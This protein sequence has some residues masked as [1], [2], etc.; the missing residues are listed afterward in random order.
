MTRLLPLLM[1]ALA[2]CTPTPGTGNPPQP[3][4]ADATTGA[5][6]AAD[7]LDAWH[8]HLAEATGAD[9]ARIA[10]LFANP[11]Q[12]LQLDF[13]QGRISVSG[14][15][16]R[17]GGGYR[18]EGG[19]LHVEQ[20][21]QTQ[22]ACPQPLMEQDAAIARL[23]EGRLAMATHDS[24]PPGLELTASDGS[25]LRFNGEPTADTRFG[26]PGERAFLEVAPQ[27]EQCPPAQEPALQCLR[28]REVFYDQDGL[29]S[30]E[31]GEWQLLSGEIEGY[32]HQPGIRNVVRVRRYSRDPAPTDTPAVVYVYDMTVE[33][34]ID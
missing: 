29:R 8:W 14:G 24:D 16:N 1:L 33:S 6:P 11:E 17:I 18:H 10:A 20:L 27:R 3:A 13:S 15:C 26:G 19:F 25:K 23:L 5:Q 21:L 31:P 7:Q 22:M 30:G 34:A 12:P 32:A 9:G 28:V 4:A 2:A